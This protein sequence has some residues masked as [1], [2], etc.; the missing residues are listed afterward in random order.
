M[1]PREERR[2]SARHM[3]SEFV[4]VSFWDERGR[5]ISEIGVLEDVSLRGVSISLNIPIP[6]GTSTRIHARDFDGQVEVRYCEPGDYGY[7]VGVEF[8]DG[9]RWDEGKWAPEHLLAV[10]DCEL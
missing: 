10:P 2:Q 6:V 5:E 1:K 7:L 9:Y 8:A 4:Q 3:C